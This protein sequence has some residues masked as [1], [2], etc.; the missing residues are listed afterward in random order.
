MPSPAMPF[1]ARRPWDSLGSWLPVEGHAGIVLGHVAPEWRKVEMY[2]VTQ[3]TLI[4]YS[5]NLGVSV[6]Q[7]C[8]TR[9]PRL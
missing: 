9:R 5:V 1:S 2:A 8:V 7:S 4:V 6:S 3:E